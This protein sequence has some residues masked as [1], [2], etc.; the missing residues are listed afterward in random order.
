MHGRV[1]RARPISHRQGLASRGFPGRGASRSRRP[2]SPRGLLLPCQS[3]E[4]LAIP[5]WPKMTIDWGTSRSMTRVSP[6]RAIRAAI[7][8]RGGCRSCGQGAEDAV[9]HGGKL[10]WHDVTDCADGQPVTDKGVRRK[11]QEVS[12][13]D[14]RNR[15]GRAAMRPTIGMIAERGP[16]PGPSRD[17]AGFCPAVA[18]RRDQLSAHPFKGGCVEPRLPQ[19]KAHQCKAGLSRVGQRRERDGKRVAV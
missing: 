11:V 1:I 12:P 18:Q 17:P 10:R 19:G 13:G 16:R 2:G 15:L 5:W 7:R 9:D 6:D 3:G 14:C 4:V 8:G